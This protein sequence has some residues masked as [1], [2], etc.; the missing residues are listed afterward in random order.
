MFDLKH[1]LT[2]IFEDQSEEIKQSEKRNAESPVILTKV[3]QMQES[4]IS[5]DNESYEFSSSSSKHVT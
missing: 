3:N 5:L 2:P 4:P 1:D